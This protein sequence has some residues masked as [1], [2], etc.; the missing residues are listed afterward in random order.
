[1]P[2]ELGAQG[3]EQRPVLGIDRA[4]PREAL[5]VGGHRAQALR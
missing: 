2:I 3:P 1:M 5:V 4:H